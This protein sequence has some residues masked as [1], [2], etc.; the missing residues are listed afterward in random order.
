MSISTYVQEILAQFAQALMLPAMIILV[1]L[2]ALAIF[3]IGSVLV[4]LVTERRH[5]QVALPEAITA[6]EQAEY[7]DVNDTVLKTPLL[8]SQKAAL[9]TVANNAGLPEDALYALA[10]AEVN[11]VATRY[12]KIVG[13]TDLITKIAPMMG[14]MCTL[15]PLGPGIVAMGQGN[16]ATLS[17]SLGVAFDGTV[18]G[19]VSAVVSMTVSHVRKVWYGRYQSA[20]EAMMTTLLEKIEHERA[21]GTELPSGFGAKDL[22]PLRLRAKELAAAGESVGAAKPEAPAAAGSAASASP[23]DAKAGE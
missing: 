8:W 23:A 13:R 15:I 20:L 5:F 6:L 3:S 14:L 1:L 18:A 19:L 22:E 4:E 10:K 16:V 7:K 21:A 11:R 17:S 2:I 12:R 9:L